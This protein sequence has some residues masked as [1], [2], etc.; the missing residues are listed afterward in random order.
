MTSSSTTERG[1]ASE[2]LGSVALFLNVT[3][4]I[5]FAVCV[6]TFALEQSLVAALAAAV[7]VGT[8]VMSMVFF[9]MDSGRFEEQRA[10]S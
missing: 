7:S 6:G 5:A 8:F 3:A 2:A 1:T 4:L 9:A 10:T